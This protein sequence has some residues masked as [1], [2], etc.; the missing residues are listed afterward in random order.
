MLIRALDVLVA[1]T[2]LVLFAPVMIVVAVLVRVQ[3]GGPAVYGADRVGR[4]GHVFRMFKFRTMIPEADRQGPLVTAGDD[5]R[6]T[7]LGRYLRRT[8]L[9]ELPSLWNVLV[10]DMSVVGPRPENSK[11]AALYNDAQRRVWSVRPG[12]TSPATMKYRNEETLLAGV[13]DLDAAYFDIMQ[14]KLRLE[15]D[16]LDRR[17]VL[18]DV[19]VLLQTI[20][21]L[22]RL[23]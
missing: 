20:R 11:S 10:G 3:S 14:D 7:P 17:T 8:K 2:G 19:A 9:D 6:I 15:L 16:Y 18:T 21:N 1:V 12:L 23:G 4:G 5:R 13:P 22:L